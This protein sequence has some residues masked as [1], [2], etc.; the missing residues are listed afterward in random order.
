MRGGALDD[1]LLNTLAVGL[2]SV[3]SARFRV[4][5]DPKYGCLRASLAKLAAECS[6]VRLALAGLSDRSLRAGVP[7]PL[8]TLLERLSLL[9]SIAC[10][11]LRMR[12]G[13]GPPTPN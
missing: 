2:V 8:T 13:C 12:S 4:G 1:G 7:P 11:Q 5:G 9:L 10:R 6:D 3:L